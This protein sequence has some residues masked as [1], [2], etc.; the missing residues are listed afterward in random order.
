M[1]GPGAGGQNLSAA[2]ASQAGPIN[3]RTP[4]ERVDLGQESMLDQQRIHRALERAINGRSQRKANAMISMKIIH[5]KYATQFGRLKGFR[6]LSR[7]LITSVD[8][9][10]GTYHQE[11][12]ERLKAESRFITGGGKQPELLEAVPAAGGEASFYRAPELARTRK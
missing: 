9:Q 4:N 12:L 8:L 11:A 5:D 6:E 10:K 2:L 1:P 7:A 3:T